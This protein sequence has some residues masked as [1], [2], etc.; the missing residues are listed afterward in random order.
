MNAMADPLSADEEQRLRQ[1]LYQRFRG[2]LVSF[3]SRRTGNRDEAEDLAQEVFVR[4]LRMESIRHLDQIDAFVFR[5]ASNLL[6]TRG[7]KIASG[8][9]PMALPNDDELSEKLLTELSERIQ[10]E[11]VLIGKQ[12]LAEVVGCLDDLGERTRD[13]F[14]LFRLEGMKQRDIAKLYGISTSTVEKVIMKATFR[15]ASRFGGAT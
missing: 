7:T 14:I 4:L 8:R 11:R 6:A 3:F 10:P 5:I 12:T 1:G 9:I 13:I 15:L 2:P